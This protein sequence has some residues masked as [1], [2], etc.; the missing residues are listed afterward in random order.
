[1][2]YRVG[3]VKVCCVYCILYLTSNEMRHKFKKIIII[4]SFVIQDIRRS[5]TRDCRL[6][7]THR[8]YIESKIV[9]GL[10]NLNSMNDKK[11]KKSSLKPRSK[12]LITRSVRS[13]CVWGGVHFFLF[14]FFFFFFFSFFFFLW[15][16]IVC[17]GGRCRH[18]VYKGV[19]PTCSKISKRSIFCV[20]SRTIFDKLPP[21]SR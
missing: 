19:I 2:A 10:I 13:V 3:G 7:K 6:C 14:F 4:I 17:V 11:R 5:C 15:Y 8:K 16:P 1:M 18:P 21:I 20:L 12:Y 9:I